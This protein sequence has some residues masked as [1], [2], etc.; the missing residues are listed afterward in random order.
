MVTI[1]GA[2]SVAEAMIAGV[3]AVHA[4][5]RARRRRARPTAPMMP[6]L[7]D[8]GSRH[9]RV[10]LPR[11]LSAAMS[12]RSIAG[13]ARRLLCR[14]RPAAG[15]TARR[16]AGVGRRAARAVRSDAADA[17]SLADRLRVPGDHAR[18]AALP[19]GAGAVPG[20]AGPRGGR[21]RARLGARASR[22]STEHGLAAGSGGWSPGWRA[23]GSRPPAGEP[24]GPVVPAARPARDYL[25]SA[26]SG[27]GSTRAL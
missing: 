1:Y 14:R 19:A 11:S 20:A 27:T 12:G 24:G 22:S 6:E 16:R 5:W 8:L 10:R 21:H 2:R 15:S 3:G 23:A 18:R 26:A 9:G 7:L 4:R 17:S 13:R 25:Y